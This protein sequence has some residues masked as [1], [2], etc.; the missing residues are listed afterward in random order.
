MSQAKHGIGGYVL[1]LGAGARARRFRFPKG[2][3]RVENKFECERSG[4]GSLQ[5]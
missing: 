4:S 5:N 2:A 3:A 1:E